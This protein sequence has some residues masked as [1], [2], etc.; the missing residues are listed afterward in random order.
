LAKPARYLLSRALLH[1]KR[2]AEEMREVV[3]TVRAAGITPAMAPAIV[4]RQE[5]AGQ[6]GA[7]LG[8]GRID[9]LDL[10]GVLDS[11]VPDGRA[12]LQSRS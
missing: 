5:L 1:G 6:I 8:R 2:R 3:K 10:D 7:R 12:S 9:S 11:L 4:E